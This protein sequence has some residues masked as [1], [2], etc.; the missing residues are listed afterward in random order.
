M[1][2][3]EARTRAIAN[4]RKE[5]QSLCSALHS[6]WGHSPSQALVHLLLKP[7]FCSVY[8]LMGVGVGSWVLKTEEKATCPLPS[9]DRQL[10][11]CDTRKLWECGEMVTGGGEKGNLTV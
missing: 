10:P 6:P 11:G 9:G 5:R 8:S 1:P 4:P 3:L 2:L 7:I